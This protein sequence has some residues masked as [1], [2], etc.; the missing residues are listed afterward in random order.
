V[1]LTPSFGS[2]GMTRRRLSWRLRSGLLLGVLPAS[3]F[4]GASPAHASVTAGIS[5]GTLNVILGAANDSA[6]VSADS[7]SAGT[8]TVSGTGLTPTT[9]VGVSSI[10]VSNAGV[11]P[12]QAVNITNATDGSGCVPFTPAV[13]TLGIASVNEFVCGSVNVTQ[14]GGTMTPTAG[15]GVPVLT[16]TGAVAGVHYATAVGTWTVSDPGVTLS[17]VDTSS[18]IG[19][20]HLGGITVNNPADDVTVDQGVST[21]VLEGAGASIDVPTARNPDPNGAASPAGLEVIGGTV[22]EVVNFKETATG[23][24]SIYAGGGAADTISIG[25][26]GSV[27]NILGPITMTSLAGSGSVGI[28]DSADSIGRTATLSGSLVTG[29]APAAIDGG[30]PAL[31]TVSGGTGVNTFGVSPL[32]SGHLN[33]GG[34]NNVATLLSMSLSGL[35]SPTLTGTASAGLVTG[36]WSFA[37]AAALDFSGF[38]ELDPTGVLIGDVSGAAGSAATS[39]GFPVTLLAPDPNAVSIPYSTA[40]GTAQ[41]PADYTAASGSLVFPANSFTPQT[42]SVTIAGTTSSGPAKTFA[43]DASSSAHEVPIRQATG[44]I[45]YPADSDLGLSGM[46]ANLSVNATSASGAVVTY[47]PPTGTDEA[48]EAPTVSCSLV[49]GSTFPIGTTT[50]TC[51][52]MD[53]DD[54]PSTV[55]ASF[56]VTVNDTDLGLS[57][58]PANIS[59]MATS[60]SGAVVTYQAP[61]AVDEAGDS[62]A[63]TVSCTP[64][65][66]ATFPVGTT[67]VTCTATSAD[68]T[69]SVVTGHFTIT[70]GV[71][72]QL[73]LSITPQTATTGTVVTASASL[74]NNASVA[75]QV[76]VRGTF[77]FVSPNGQTRQFSSVSQTIALAPGQTIARTFAFK[78]PRD[79]PRGTYSFTATA[80]DVTG[81]ISSA[82]AFTVT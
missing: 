60:S 31:L 4:L 41:S 10:N 57:G 59:A 74:T 50:V 25:K 17:A 66:G 24:S 43:V 65:S 68:D 36:R 69:P 30:N 2:G 11:N 12:G 56:T 73:L 52:A 45:T 49:S 33:L 78:V 39:F 82:A 47:A 75:R 71:D 46:P 54:T 15:A 51:S 37:N 64:A 44:T 22:P 18:G 38:G 72:L 27:Q 77:I 79:A 29:L 13:A 55:S 63:A 67:T 80:T 26:S 28:D 9:F 81:S 34:G 23:L 76:T 62:P 58:L 40:D 21:L 20:T 16:V 70:V 48:G 1:K 32:S 6:V 53:A 19:G 14:S 5:A 35:T 61:I 42:I 8:I 3:L 7:R